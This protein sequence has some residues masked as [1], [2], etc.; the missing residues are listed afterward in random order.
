MINQATVQVAVF[1][2]VLFSLSLMK[3]IDLYKIYQ[4]GHLSATGIGRKKDRGGRGENTLCLEA[5]K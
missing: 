5:K 4:A 1:V 3:R 2:C